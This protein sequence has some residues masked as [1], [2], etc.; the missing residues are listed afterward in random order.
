MKKEKKKYLFDMSVCSAM[1]G[2]E[3]RETKYEV[4]SK[5][6]LSVRMGKEKVVH[7]TRM[8]IIRSVKSIYLNGIFLHK[9]DKLFRPG[10]RMV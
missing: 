5:V 4:K 10:S 9:Q 3:R 6:D 2:E 1:R 8:L 7:F